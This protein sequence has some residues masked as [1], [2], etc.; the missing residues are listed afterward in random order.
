MDSYKVCFHC[1]AEYGLHRSETDQ[2]PVG[3][4]EETREGH[5]QQWSSNTFLDADAVRLEKAAPQMLEA[6]IAVRRHGLV[7]TDGYETVVKLV[8]EAISAAGKN[9]SFTAS[10][11]ESKTSTRLQLHKAGVSGSLPDT[12]ILS[13]LQK[14]RYQTERGEQE[15]KMY[16]DVDMPKIIKAAIAHFSSGNDR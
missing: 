4:V 9:L 2:C 14:Q 15:Y 10:P 13:W 7:E 8:G 5:K 3:G 1:G 6:L 16:F 12:E 11:M